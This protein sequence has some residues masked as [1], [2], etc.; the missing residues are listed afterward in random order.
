MKWEN[1]TV[2]QFQQIH[3]ILLSQEY[4]SNFDRLI[5]IA[6]YLLD[7]PLN[8][9]TT[10]EIK[11]MGFLLNIELMP[12]KV[13]KYF[14]FKGKTYKP[15]LE[16]NRFTAGQYIDFTTY[17]K[18][19][20]KVIDN[21]HFLAAIICRESTWYGAEKKYSA[22]TMMKRA[23]LF[24]DLPI[25]VIYPLTLFFSEFLNALTDS[26]QGYLSNLISQVIKELTG[27]LT[28]GDGLSA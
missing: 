3:K 16:V 27:M 9:I 21:L 11:S 19:K 1:I 12:N 6:A 14:R 15:T 17:L 23:D 4:D 25:T 8:E 2:R 28:D 10:E 22:V 24:L 5:D 13:S 20:D 7:K 18:D 26:I